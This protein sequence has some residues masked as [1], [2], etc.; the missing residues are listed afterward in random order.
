MAYDKM[1]SVLFCAS[2]F[3]SICPGY[4]K[5]CPILFDTVSRCSITLCNEDAKI[6]IPSPFMMLHSQITNPP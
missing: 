2:Q 4:H 5:E 3:R 6:K 1:V